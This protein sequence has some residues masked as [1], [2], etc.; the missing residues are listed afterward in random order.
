MEGIDVGELDGED[1]CIVGLDGLIV[2]RYVVGAAELGTDDG[3]VVGV[4]VVVID[5]WA[6]EEDS[7]MHALLFRMVFWDPSV[8]SMET[9]KPPVSRTDLI[10]CE[11]GT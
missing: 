6:I 7:W 5:I 8:P 11:E 1:G 4:E 10:A 9:C 2:G 3:L